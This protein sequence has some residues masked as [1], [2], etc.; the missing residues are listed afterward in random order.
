MVCLSLPL[1]K[2]LKPTQ[3]LSRPVTR[4]RLVVEANKKVQK[5]QKVRA[6][7]TGTCNEQH[8][9][10]CSGD[11]TKCSLWALRIGKTSNNG[12]SRSF[13]GT[14]PAHQA[15]RGWRRSIDGAAAAGGGSSA[16]AVSV[17]QREDAGGVAAAADAGLLKL[18]TSRDQPI[19]TCQVI[20]VKDLENVGKEGEL[21]TV[22]VGY[23]RNYL[24]PNGIARIA[25]EG[26]LE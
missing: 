24:L 14:W 5:K 13:P 21:L 11:R 1:Q 3:C 15:C 10:K 18:I 25:S 12:M 17:W 4:T 23:L 16:A 22:P 6:S 2:G 8:W 19:Q 26:I 9:L 7:L 20:L